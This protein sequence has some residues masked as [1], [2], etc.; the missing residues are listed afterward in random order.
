[1]WL[2]RLSPKPLTNYALKYGVQLTDGQSKTL[3]AEV[4]K[5]VTWSVT[6]T[7]ASWA[8]DTFTKVTGETIQSS[9]LLGMTDTPRAVGDSIAD[10]TKANPRG[11]VFPPTSA[12]GPG[13]AR[14]PERQGGSSSTTDP[15]PV[16]KHKDDLK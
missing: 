16:K 7:C 6:C 10:K 13:P 15:K 2:L 3:D 1:M 4:G 5:N 9:E 12:G 11:G 14:K 8:A